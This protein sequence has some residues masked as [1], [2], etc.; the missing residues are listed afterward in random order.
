[1]LLVR[2]VAHFLLTE[3][4]TSHLR[5]KSYTA[6]TVVMFGFEASC[7]FNVRDRSESSFIILG[8][9]SGQGTFGMSKMFCFQSLLYFVTLSAMPRIIM[10][11]SDQCHAH[12]SC[13]ILSKDDTDE[14]KMPCLV[15][16]VANSSLCINPA[17]LSRSLDYHEMLH[18]E[19][20]SKNHRRCIIHHDRHPKSCFICGPPGNVLKFLPDKGLP[21]HIA[22]VSD[23]LGTFTSTNQKLLVYFPSLE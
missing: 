6:N 13:S 14:G 17:I 20:T 12:I 9:I 22:M 4:H 11:L 16:Y 15:H 1:M 3:H 19:L 8:I 18:F 10:K 23:A 21:L 7:T 2:I 5:G